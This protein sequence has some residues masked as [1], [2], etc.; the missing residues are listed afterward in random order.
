MV[1]TYHAMPLSVEYEDVDGDNGR[2][3]EH[4]G[5][6]LL[7]SGASGVGPAKSEAQKEGHATLSSS[8][9]NLSNTII[10][11]GACPLHPP[12]ST[13]VLFSSRSIVMV[14]RHAHFSSGTFFLFVSAHHVGS[15]PRLCNY[16]RPSRLPASSLAC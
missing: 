7:G 6:A 8:I 10:G 9:V 16:C 15:R 4:E 1:Q 3:A 11:S 13:I 5:S 2:P 12:Y 14:F